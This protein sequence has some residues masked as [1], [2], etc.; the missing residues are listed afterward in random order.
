MVLVRIGDSAEIF[1]LV[2]AKLDAASSFWSA[3]V[4]SLSSFWMIEKSITLSKGTGV[5]TLP[6]LAVEEVGGVPG[7]LEVGGVVLV[8][9]EVAVLRVVRRVGVAEHGEASSAGMP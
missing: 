1:E 9:E 6:D 4:P 3:N 2:G 5:P 7:A 8:Q